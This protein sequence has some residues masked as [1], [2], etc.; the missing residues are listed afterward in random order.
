MFRQEVRWWSKILL[1]ENRG[2]ENQSKSKPGLDFPKIFVKEI[3]A[4]PENGTEAN[5]MK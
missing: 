2:N 1:A 5:S 4:K 3:K